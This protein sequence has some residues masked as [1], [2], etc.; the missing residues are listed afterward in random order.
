M[1]EARLLRF[2]DLWKQS[3]ESGLDDAAQAELDAFLQDPALV[4]QLSSWQAQHSGL[5]AQEPGETPRL[6]K[7]VRDQFRQRA[8]LR[9][10]GPWALG[11]FVAIGAAVLTYQWASADSYKFVQVPAEE[12]GVAAPEPKAGKPRPTPRPT[13]GLPPG[14][15]SRPTRL[16]LHIGRTV[17]LSW[18]LEKA[19]DARI[20]VM[21]RDGR[22]VKTLWQGKAKAGRY[23]SA[24]DGT[25]QMGRPALP[26][27]YKLTAVGD[28]ILLAEREIELS[29][30][31][32]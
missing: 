14:F 21:D 24:W 1:M 27:P 12:E 19:A 4:E 18:K 23:S 31:K 22:V 26:G 15:G 2:V 6:D 3:L 11:A 30:A 9:Q 13:L 10:A 7:R 17:Q 16:E 25:D 32:E 8:M 29:T 28:G 5:E 20:S